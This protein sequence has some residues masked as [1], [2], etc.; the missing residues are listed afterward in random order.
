M[1]YKHTIVNNVAAN[2]IS[3]AVELLL[4]KGY[5]TKDESNLACIRGRLATVQLHGVYHQDRNKIHTYDCGRFTISFSNTC[6][7]IDVTDI[8]RLVISVH[9]NLA[10]M[11][12][13]MGNWVDTIMSRKVSNDEKHI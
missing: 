4:A 11:Y 3:E 8:S 12:S 13:L 9:D 2:L 6:A 1:Q 10:S 5:W 7:T